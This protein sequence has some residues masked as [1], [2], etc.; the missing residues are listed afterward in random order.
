VDG[1]KIQEA[2]RL[3]QI[4]IGNWRWLDGHFTAQGINLLSLPLHRLLNVI[5]V[6]A[7]E[8]KPSDEVQAWIDSLTAPLPGEV[9]ID[10]DFDDSFD[11]IN[12]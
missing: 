11:Q 3:A 7:A 4:C 6:W 8:R 10:P 9:G 2:V 12:R 1:K 5:F